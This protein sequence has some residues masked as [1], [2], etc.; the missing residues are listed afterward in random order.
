MKQYKAPDNSVH[1]IDPEH[2]HFL[3]IGCVEITQA[4]ASALCIINTPKT[5]PKQEALAYLVETDWTVLR[6]IETGKAIPEEVVTK[7][8]EAR[9]LI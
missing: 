8:S 9:K 3:P 2:V 1:C 4:E 6:F 7:R 5:D